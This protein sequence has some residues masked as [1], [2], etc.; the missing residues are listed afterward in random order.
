MMVLLCIGAFI[1]Q[2]PGCQQKRKHIRSSAYGLNRTATLYNNNG[3]IIKSWSGMMKVEENVGGKTQ[4]IMNGDT[5][6]LSGTYVIEE[7]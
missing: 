4:F 1:F 6:I 5:V 2:M 3:G 7:N